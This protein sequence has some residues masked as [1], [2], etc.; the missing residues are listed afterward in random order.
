VPVVLAAVAT[1]SPEPGQ[2]VEPLWRTLAFSS[3]E[4]YPWAVIAPF[5][6]GWVRRSRPRSS[7]DRLRVIAGHVALWLGFALAHQ[8]VISTVRAA[9][10]PELAG[11]RRGLPFSLVPDGVLYLAVMA[12]FA[13]AETRRRQTRVGDA[14]D[15]SPFITDKPQGLGLGLVISRDIVAGFSGELSH[16]SSA[17]GAVFR[18]TLARAK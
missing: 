2:A 4:W 8:L 16:V 3:A 12:A 17:R 18:I 14:T 10:A 11:V 6:D 15:T 5:I 13:I 9:A 7:I 1:R